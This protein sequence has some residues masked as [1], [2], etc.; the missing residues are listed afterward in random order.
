MINNVMLVGRLGNAP[1]QVETSTETVIAKFTLATSKTI[2]GQE[3]VQWHNIKCFNKTAE[4]ALK[5]LY[6]GKLV[7]IEG[8]I[9]YSTY[10]EGADKKYFTSIIANRVQMLGDKEKESSFQSDDIVF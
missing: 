3:K 8:E 6:K 2:K 9:E 7:S 5:Y 1:E 4:V 10:G